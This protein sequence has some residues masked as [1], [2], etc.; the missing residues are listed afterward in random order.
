MSTHATGAAGFGPNPWQQTSWDWRAAGN[1]IGGGA[2]SGLL[3]I[4]ALF[5]AANTST[6]PA[7]NV[8]LLLA[9]TLTGLG[10]LCVWLEIGRPLRALHVFFNPRTSWM[11]REAF[12]ALLLFPAGLLALLNVV[13]SL[14]ASA[15]LALLFLYCQSRMLPATRGIPAW[16]SKLLTPLMFVTGLCEG[17]GLF[18]L[19]GPWHGAVIGLFL[20]LLVARLVLWRRYRSAVEP[21]LVPRARAALNQAGRMLLFIGTVAPLLL[22]GARAFLVNGGA[23]T[24]MLTFAGALAAVA[25]FYLKYALVTRASFNQGFSLTKLPVRGV[26]TRQ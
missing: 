6:S 22:L 13:G 26:R 24:P 16:R 15:A 25:G 7:F 8:P 18:F 12:V 4:S 14:W 2:G 3:V 10:L 23:Q 17:C 19:L 11:S 9:L 20:L 5:A 21:S 1:F